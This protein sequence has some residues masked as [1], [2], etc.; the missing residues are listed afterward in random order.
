MELITADV[1]DARGRE[2][3]RAIYE[4]GFSEHIRSPFDELWDDTILVLAGP[5]PQ[6][7]AVVRQLGPTSWVFLRYFVV[8]AERRGDGVGGR[9]WKLLTRAMADAGH[10]RIVFDVEDP[11]ETSD[12]AEALIRRRRI[13]FYERL[14]AQL[15]PVNGYMPPHGDD[16]HPMLLMAADLDV[17]ATR[18]LGDDLRDVLIA[19]YR[20]RYGLAPGDPVVRNTLRQ[21][22]L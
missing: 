3:L 9:L 14:G 19:G 7:M 17:R 20:Y 21:S 16:T 11:T 8:A 1:L 12:P 6:G 2:D 22:G 15:L 18:I 10:T 4:Q 13:G 5:A